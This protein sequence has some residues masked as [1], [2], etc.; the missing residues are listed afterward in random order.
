MFFSK[1][2]ALTIRL[3]IDDTLLRERLVLTA[4]EYE[5]LDLLKQEGFKNYDPVDLRTIVR[6]AFEEILDF[7]P[8]S[9]SLLAPEEY[10]LSKDQKRSLIP[11]STEEYYDKLLKQLPSWLRSEFDFS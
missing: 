10:S 4:D 7:F 5:A 2:K 8:D 3:I 11:Q 6:A 1:K 9:S